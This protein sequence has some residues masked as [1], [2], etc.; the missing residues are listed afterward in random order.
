VGETA[1]EMAAAGADEMVAAVDAIAVS[2]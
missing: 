1:D 2:N